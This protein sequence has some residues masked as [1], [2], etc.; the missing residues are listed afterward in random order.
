[1]MMTDLFLKAVL[2]YPYLTIDEDV[3]M[4]FKR[5]SI[6]FFERL[7]LALNSRILKP[8]SLATILA[9]ED[10]P[11]PGGPESMHALAFILGRS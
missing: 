6:V 3:H 7:S 2:F 8:S 5:L 10:L 9:D 11:I 1:M 4:S